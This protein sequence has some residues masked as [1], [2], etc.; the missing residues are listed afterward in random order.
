MNSRQVELVQSSFEHVR[1]VAAIAAGLFYGRLFEL[2][3]SLRAMF[4]GDM[5]E[6]GKKLMGMLGFVVGNLKRPET[7]LP[8]VQALGRRHVGYG[9][10]PGHYAVVGEALLWTLETALG[11]DF[12][13]E[14]RE[15]W[16]AAYTLLARV[17]QE[18]AQPE[19]VPA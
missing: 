2:D 17:M 16:T 19:L 14:V 5:Q 4:R 7:I 8:S 12:T 10:Q 11:D 9:V 13:Q 18:A 15:A 6:Q 3:P 1:P